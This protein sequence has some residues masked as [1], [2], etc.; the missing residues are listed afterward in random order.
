M[1]GSLKKAQ[2]VLMEIVTTEQTYIKAME[3]VIKQ[4]RPLIAETMEE[5]NKCGIIVPEDL[6]GERM[7]MVFGNIHQLYEEHL[8]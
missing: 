7:R 6:K 4:W 5:G 1:A 2:Q 8:K 3:E